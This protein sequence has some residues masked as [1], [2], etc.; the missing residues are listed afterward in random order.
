MHANEQKGL[1]E[2]TGREVEYSLWTAPPDAIDP[3]I[4]VALDAFVQTEPVSSERSCTIDP[5]RLAAF[6]KP[7]TPD[8]LQTPT[9]S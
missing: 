2:P 7:V 1:D 9:Q 4:H 8:V 3:P 5:S 6:Q